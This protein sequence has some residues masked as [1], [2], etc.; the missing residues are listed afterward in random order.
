MIDTADPRRNIAIALLTPDGHAQWTGSDAASTFSP[1]L[2]ALVSGKPVTDWWGREHSQSIA[3]ALEQARTTGS[4]TLNLPALPEWMQGPHWTLFLTQLPDTAGN[5]MLLQMTAKHQALEDELSLLRQTNAQ[6][7]RRLETKRERI[8][9]L[10][11][12]NSHSDKVQTMGAFVASV[13]HDM[14]NVLS[15]MTSAQRIV[16]RKLD[17]QVDATLFDEVDA[18]VERG[19]TLLRQLLDF[20]RKD[21]L[22]P[23]L[24]DP[25][26]MLDRDRGLMQQLIGHS[27]RLELLLPEDSWSV[28]CEPGRFAAVV[29]NLL[30]NACDAIRQAGR[31]GE[32]RVSL[33]NVPLE[34]RPEGTFP[35]DYLCLSIEDTG[36]GMSPEVLARL[37]EPYFTTKPRGAGTGLGLQSAYN[38][39]QRCG[40]TVHVTSTEG[41]GTRID[42]YLARAILRGEMIEL[43]GSIQ[44]PELHGDAR[45]LLVEASDRL[46]SALADLLIGLRYD[47]SR[48]KTPREALAAL[49]AAPKDL[50]LL[51]IDT[52]ADDVEALI[53]ELQQLAPRCSIIC[54]TTDLYPLSGV[55][56]LHKPISELSL[57]QALLEHL[58]RH[59]GAGL[60]LRAL[61]I[62]AQAGRTLSNPAMRSTFDLWYEQVNRLH[63]LPD[64]AL[65]NDLQAPQ[66]DCSFLIACDRQY[67]TGLPMLRFVWAGSE[68][69]RR[70][71]SDLTGLEITAAHEAY[72]GNIRDAI[73]RCLRGLADVQDIPENGQRLLLPLAE[74]RDGVTHLF[75]A[76]T[77]TT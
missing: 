55:A 68:M 39:A 7:M 9:V 72:L 30:S 59:P 6:L 37:G 15:V 57:S 49:T 51:D 58:E 75:G 17:G 50:I 54:M 60:S 5:A 69:E 40:G 45:I 71:D 77:Q 56:T 38:L 44:L 76:L 42:I 48:T 23:E 11:Q 43:A 25:S 52:V 16:R 4:A 41:E 62:S 2:E 27:N 26:E 70:L 22:R 64:C 35:R 12:V 36:A 61:E 74:G 47:V 18:S 20:S 65:V 3:N 13:V 19:R 28:Y 73:L 21:D 63:A 67:E 66:P 34:D 33:R 29:F 14:N 1:D 10:E 53:A 24:A 46:A 8:R 31:S 32:V